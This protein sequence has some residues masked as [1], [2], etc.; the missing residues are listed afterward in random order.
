MTTF[1]QKFHNQNGNDIK[2]VKR[3]QVIT[4]KEVIAL[5]ILNVDYNYVQCTE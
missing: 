2:V 1:Y 5:K 3:V 4:K